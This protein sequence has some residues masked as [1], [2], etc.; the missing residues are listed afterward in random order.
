MIEGIVMCLRFMFFLDFFFVVDKLFMLWG[1]EVVLFDVV[2]LK[3]FLFVF[4]WWDVLVF[5]DKKWNSEDY[6]YGFCVL[7]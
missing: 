7:L 4:V 1:F 5:I 6:F 2:L 3:L